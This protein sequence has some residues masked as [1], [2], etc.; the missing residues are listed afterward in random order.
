M[1]ES[2]EVRL[3][4]RVASPPLPDRRDASVS[5]LECEGK[6]KRFPNSDGMIV[7]LTLKSGSVHID[8]IDGVTVF[9]FTQPRLSIHGEIVQEMTEPLLELSGEPAPRILF[10]LTNVDFFTSAFIELLIRIWNRLKSRP[11]SEM[12][13]CC[14]HPYCRDVLD[15]TNMTSVVHLYPSRLEALAAM[16]REH[17]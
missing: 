17:A 16:C 7:M 9:S 15:I 8:E 11:D 12:S 2:I 13:L 10:D 1:R 4:V 3:L 5:L 14:V 6:R